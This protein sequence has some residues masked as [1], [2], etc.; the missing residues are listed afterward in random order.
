MPATPSDRPEHRA[1]HALLVGIDDYPAG[2]PSLTGCLNDIAAAHDW[3]RQGVDGPV[4]V[5]VLT[6][7]SATVRAVI[8]GIT[9]HLGRA[10]PG[11]T[12]LLWFSGHGTEFAAGPERESTEATGYSQALVCHDGPLLDK[13]LG[14]LLAESAGRGVHTVAVLDCCYS[15]GATRDHGLTARWAPPE[16]WWRRLRPAARD[17]QAPP[18]AAS[19]VLLAAC[20][21]NELAYE[22]AFS[23][24]Q[25]GVF[26]RAL[27]AALAGSGPAAAYRELLAAAHCRVQVS[28]GFQHPTLYP[29]DAGGPA[30]QPLLGGAVRYPGAALLRQGPDGWEVDYGAS[31]GLRDTGGAEGTEFT[32]TSPDAPDP[33]TGGSGEDPEGAATAPEPSAGGPTSTGPYS[34]PGS[35]SQ[36]ADPGAGTTGSRT[37]RAHTVRADRTLVV[38]C[39]WVPR[40][41]QVYPVAVSALAVPPA[42]VTTDAPGEPR[43]ARWLRTAL[44]SAGPGGGPSPL[45]RSGTIVAG[46]LGFR[47][48]IRAGAARVLRRDGSQAVPPLPF[49]GE[50]DAWRVADCL[51]HLTRWHR[52]RDLSNVASPLNSLVG[53]EIIPSGSSTAEPPDGGGE[54]VFRYGTGPE[55]PREPLVSIRIH[56]RSMSR[57]LWCVLLDL[58][59]SYA[60]HTALY[61]GDFIGP[62]RIG[63]ALDG[64]PVRL[65]L[66]PGRPAVP[67]AEVGDW[68]KLI[69]AEGELNTVPFEL[70]AWRP[71]APTGRE[72]GP[73]ADGLLRFAAP[74]RP[75]R[76]L[77][78]T[79]PRPPGQWG[80][81]T[82]P[83]RTVV[84]GATVPDG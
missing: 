25:Q 48:A 84:P 47:V 10:E 20:R 56:N 38:P 81:V 15:G 39:G 5:K 13:D 55:G 73:A 8:D 63:L 61:R 9:G 69:V 35:G 42:W 17:V 64:E 76:D 7:G 45:V 71:E 77:G 22:D 29:P 82:L 30:D 27:L 3:L 58:T 54:R 75:S 46:S 33:G 32:V 16:P 67:G 6:N 66:P 28:T 59:D 51:V 50:H 40:A 36:K 12:A 44:A 62:G 26:S 57:T 37:V 78:P 43:A 65:S 2:R 49:E 68:L 18:A 74:T 80:V 52:L 19:Y 24:H 23:G 53:V 72:T 1:V 83:L 70:P 60:S 4:R 11:D 31:H 14:A 34:G 41:G 21:L 79:A